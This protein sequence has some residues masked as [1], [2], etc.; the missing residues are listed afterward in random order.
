MKRFLLLFFISP[1][2]L[3]AQEPLHIKGK[4]LDSLSGETLP[5]VVVKIAGIGGATTDLQGEF[6]ILVPSQTTYELSFSLV[7]YRTKKISL[8]PGQKNVSILLAE[9][10][11]EFDMVVVSA[12]KFEQKVEELTVSIEILKPELIENKNTNN[13]ESVIDQVPGISMMEGQCNIRGGS[14]F[15]Y[16][17][18]SRVL[19]LVDELP[20]LSAD[21]GDVKWNFLPVENISQVEVIKGASS[22]MFGSSALNGV[23]NVRTAYPTSTP[24]SVLSFSSGFYNDPKSDTLN[25]WG[26]NNPVFSNLNFFHSRQIGQLDL[27]LAGQL[28]SDEGFRM[29]EKE[30]RYRI[31]SNL[32]WRN[33]KVSG[34]SYGVNFNRMVTEGGLFILWQN[35]DS[36]Y[37]PQNYSLQLY[38]NS[39]TSVDPF[40]TY[41][42][43]KD[44]R[45]SIRGRFYQTD[46]TNDMQQESTADLY[47]GEYQYQKRYKKDLTVTTGITGVYSEVNSDSMYKY[48]TSTNFS[49]F[50]QWD[51][52]W[53]RFTFSAG[54]RGEF[55]KVDTA[56][57][58]FN[59]PIGKNTISL[60]VYPVVRGGVNYKAA[61]FTFVRAS[62]G[63][64]YR[65]PTVAEKYVSTTV[66]S[67]KTFPNPDLQPEHGWSA[68]IGVKQ[69][70]KIKK[71][72]G[73]IDLSG[74]WTEYKDMM[75]F[76]LDYY[77]PES[78]TN[79][80]LID[81]LDWFGA[82]SV[83]VGHT[84]ITGAELTLTGAG[85][86]GKELEVS[87]LAGYTYINPINLNMDSAYRATF[88]D[89]GSNKLKYRW[90]H[91]GKLDI[92]FDY[93]KFSLG[94]SLRY[95]SFMKN[96]DKRFED[97]LMYD[98]LPGLE[99]YILPG[100]KAYREEHNK[101]D[102][103]ADLRFG[104]EAN[105]TA[106]INFVINNLFN[107]E[108][109]SR[110]GDML[111]P[112]NSAVQLLI[113]W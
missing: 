40:L 9:D 98:V 61:E 57:T 42:T 5:G 108:Y 100:L 12:G 11:T 95:N 102:L 78:I 39:R 107:R 97:K 53:K 80:S 81:Y 87:I 43:K 13:M 75:E 109:M 60:P 7:G 65:F 18:G 3:F 58:E 94:I 23:I 96:I 47:Y 14:G 35:A 62:Y 4:V 17:A 54:I 83:N 10:V 103:V 59:I 86:I 113:K 69:G 82:K 104:W 20:M 15:S 67:L 112:R 26:K 36:A 64:G 72:A 25:W 44:S 41:L 101:G 52:K 77:I 106:K 48:H 30:Q 16:G 110:P 37:I 21:A 66:N 45:H 49:F 6:I 56:Q 63:Q 93:K 29:L 38:S 32:R 84:R 31:N 50:G 73:F 85:K 99:L 89:S 68:E 90:E 46:N 28:F 27:V 91:V 33:K 76:N 24:K 8:E 22:A 74:F 88:S 71:W 105:K 92:Q 79:P 111:A 2:F 34:L 55:F 70:V 51:K 19:L 1:V